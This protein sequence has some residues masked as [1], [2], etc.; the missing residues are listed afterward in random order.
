[1]TED[2]MKYLIR[3][4]KERCYDL[5]QKNAGGFITDESVGKIISARDEMLENLAPNPSIFCSHVDR[6]IETAIL[7]LP[8]GEHLLKKYREEINNLIL[9]D[10]TITGQ[11][12]MWYTRFFKEIQGIT[13]SDILY[14]ALP[15]QIAETDN[16][17][18]VA[19]WDILEP[20]KLSL[21]YGEFTPFT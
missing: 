3:H 10:S 13:I 21:N 12:G 18:I 11:G 7:L 16:S 5:P 19:H 6:G 2:T 14:E 8:G 9:Q 20:R 17:I 1:M 15:K 4:G